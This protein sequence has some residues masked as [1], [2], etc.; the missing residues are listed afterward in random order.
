VGLGSNVDRVASIRLALEVLRRDHEVVAV[1]PIYESPAGGMEAPPFLNLA[2]VLETPLAPEDLRGALK[3]LEVACGRP[4]DHDSW[5]PRTMDADLLLLG[6]LVRPDLGI[7]D[8]DVLE[9]PWVLVPLADAAPDLVHP[10]EGRAIADLLRGRPAWRERLAR[11]A[12]VEA[13][14][15][16]R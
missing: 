2:V 7:P 15:E 11:R 14:V 9:A 3:E 6:D 16:G 8:P 5:A 13:E 10:V 12:D 1:S 4:R